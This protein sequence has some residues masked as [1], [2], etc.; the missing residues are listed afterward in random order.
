[1][2]NF[3]RVSYES[4]IDRARGVQRICGGGSMLF[5]VN[6]RK[7]VLLA[8]EDWTLLS[9][10]IAKRSLLPI[11][12]QKSL[13]L[14]GQRFPKLTAEAFYKFGA[15]SS[16]QFSAEVSRDANLLAMTGLVSIDVIEPGGRGYR[17]TPAG[18]ERARELE[19]RADPD[20]IQFL[21]RTVAWVRTRSVDQLLD[22]SLEPASPAPLP[23]TNPPLLR[24]R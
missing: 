18:L 16:G 5:R 7:P 17:V 3:D 1:L 19:S 4:R 21:R 11:Q 24:R 12:L 13:Y 8:R 22:G 6:P 2:P 23:T 20:A 14:L 15:T 9:M 10:A